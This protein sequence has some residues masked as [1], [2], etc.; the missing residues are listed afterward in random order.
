M[1]A[2]R[3]GHQVY[4]EVSGARDGIPVLYLHGGPG[5]VLHEG[6]RRRFDPEKYRIIGL[7]QRGAGRSTPTAGSPEHRLEDNTTAHLLEDIEALREHLGVERWLVCGVSWG[8]TLALHHALAHTDRVL[9]LVLVCVTT[10]SPT[11]VEWISEGASMFYPEAWAEL[12]SVVEQ[13]S[14]WKPGR[15]RLV[16]AMTAVMAGDD[17][18]ARLDLALAWMAWEE[19]HIQIGLPVDQL[20]PVGM[21]EKPVDQQIAF[22]TLVGHFWSHHAAQTPG[23]VPEGGLLAHL[24]QLQGLPICMVHGRRDV[25]GP[26]STA[27]AVKAE[28][29]TAQLHV[30]ES[31]GHGGAHMMDLWRR[32]TDSFAATGGFE[33]VG[34]AR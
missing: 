7:Q 19:T 6:Y 29:P 10:T 2:A 3:A 17:A 1:L 12:A 27:W 33:M 23:W 34:Q 26:L 15:G 9:G 8:S 28:L 31:E 4:W 18:E 5:G 32:A 25:S 24:G 13:H 11:E 14:D 21:C 30:V 16:D 20:R 22:T